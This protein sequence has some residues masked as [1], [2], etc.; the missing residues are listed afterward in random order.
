MCLRVRHGKPTETVN[1]LLGHSLV[2]IFKG[3][4]GEWTMSRVGV[5][6]SPRTL[7]SQVPRARGTGRGDMIR[8]ALENLA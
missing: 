4:G 3:L 2:Q 6:G 8:R 1:L 7:M 5:G